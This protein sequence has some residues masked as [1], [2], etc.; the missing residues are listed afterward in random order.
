[1]L[2]EALQD[3][4]WGNRY[5]AADGLA[6]MG[7]EAAE[8]LPV[9]ISVLVSPDQHD[10]YRTPEDIGTA[11]YR[12]APRKGPAE[13]LRLLREGAKVQR[14]QAARALGAIG[15][16]NGE[17]IPALIEM[18]GKENFMTRVYAIEALG[19]FGDKAAAAV[20]VIVE[21]IEDKSEPGIVAD[22]ALSAL[23]EIGPA[24]R[25]AIP[26]IERYAR[27]ADAHDREA[28]SWALRKIRG[29]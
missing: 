26:A 21:A 25:D 20:P 14:Q 10:A 3:K 1:V 22:A 4:T 16:G 28:A 9:L 13:A 23:G 2:L 6:S 18:A 7:T 19:K 17:A 11:I 12:V 15:P 27:R 24:A 8:A 5:L 29:R